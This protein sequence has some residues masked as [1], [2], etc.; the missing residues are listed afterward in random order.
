M[1]RGIMAPYR[2]E[3]FPEKLSMFIDTYED[4]LNYFAGMQTRR[5]QGGAGALSEIDKVRAK[6][7]K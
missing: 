1:K 3:E 4:W 6:W 2:A 7:S 5:D